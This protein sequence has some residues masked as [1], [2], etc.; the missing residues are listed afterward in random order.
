MINLYVNKVIPDQEFRS[1]IYS[2]ALILYSKLATNADF[3]D[4]A[5]KCVLNEFGDDID[6]RLIHVRLPIDEFVKKVAALKAEF[7]NSIQSKAHI[8]DFLIEIGQ[9]PKDYFLDV[10]RIRVVPDYDYL[11][12]GVSYAYLPH[13]DTWYGAADCQ[14]NT[15][16]PIFPISADQTMMLN[17]YYFDRPVK[18]TSG[19]WDLKNW[20][21][22]ER[23]AAKQHIAAENRPHPLSLEQIRQETELRVAGESGD[24]IVFSGA[25]LHG[26]VRNNSGQVRFSIDFRIYHC[27]DLLSRRGAR[28]Q[29]GSAKNIEFGYRDLFRAS[30]FEPYSGVIK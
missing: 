14:I 19:D 4:Y 29:D 8:R 27:E 22:N 24:M 3:C 26:T 17:P 16:M 13:R 18:N 5:K 21:M 23:P 11:H 12:A 9:D 1:L 2:G 7:T 10:P 30:D 6:P 28:N 20:V 15:W 25:H